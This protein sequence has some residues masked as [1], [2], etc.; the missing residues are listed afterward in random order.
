MDLAPLDKTPAVAKD[1]AAKI[2]NAI[3]EQIGAMKSEGEIPEG[4]DADTLKADAVR[5]LTGFGAVGPLL[6]DEEVHEIHCLRHD[7]VLVMKASGVSL[8]ETSFSSDVAL[9]RVI[10]R[11]ADASDGAPPNGETIVDRRTAKGAH[12]MAFLPPV[13]G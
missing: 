2:E 12:L 13:S 5:E 10:L 3:A 4:A 8:A 9:R 6:D 1:F 11:L 7:Q